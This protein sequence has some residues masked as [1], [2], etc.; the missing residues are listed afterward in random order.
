MKLPYSIN[1]I[2]HLTEG[3]LFQEGKDHFDVKTLL[4]DSRRVS[5]PSES[6]FIAVKGER[7]NGHKFISEAYH[8]GLRAF[9]VDEDI[10]L[11]LLKDAWVI[12]VPN[13]LLSL[14]LMAHKHLNNFHFPV[15]GITGSNGKTIVK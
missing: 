11:S 1:D 12:R 14:Q 6:I 2:I 13:T 15:I 5:N 8:K 7:N 9:V 4:I 10:N 3:E